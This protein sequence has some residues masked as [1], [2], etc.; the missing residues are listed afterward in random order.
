MKCT[1]FYDK[2]LKCPHFSR[3]GITLFVCVFVCF[4]LGMGWT[5]HQDEPSLSLS[6]NFPLCKVQPGTNS[7]H[8]GTR[9]SSNSPLGLFFTPGLSFPVCP[10]MSNYRST[11]D[12]H[13]EQLLAQPDCYGLRC[14]SRDPA[15]P[16]GCAA[17][18]WAHAFH[19]PGLRAAAGSSQDAPQ[20]R[21]GKWWP[22]R[23]AAFLES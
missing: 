2:L 17:A 23:L 12:S 3:Q 10:T 5:P 20:L 9:R 7:M 11:K 1:F 6:L 21:G 8:S 15:R 19:P 18:A 22:C 16:L 13:S 14:L 4:N